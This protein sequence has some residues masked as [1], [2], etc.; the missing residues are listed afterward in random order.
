MDNPSTQMTAE[1]GPHPS[2]HLRLSDASTFDY[3]CMNCS[4]TDRVPG[5]WGELLLPCPKPR[6]GGEG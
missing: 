3:I 4:R 2:H 1:R 5:G 6:L